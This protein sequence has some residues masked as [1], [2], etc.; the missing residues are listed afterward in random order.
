M[1]NAIRKINLKTAGIMAI[2]FYL[3]TILLH[4]LVLTGILPYQWVNGGRSESLAAQLPLSV[5]NMLIA[6]AGLLFTLFA[7][8]IIRNNGKKVITVICWVFV[9][10]W[11]VGFFQQ[12]LGTVFEKTAVALLLL[13]GVIAHLRMAVEER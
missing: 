9:A 2:V 4:I 13:V 7:S 8:R 12:L 1:L 11:T 5:S 10:L 6:V 3:L